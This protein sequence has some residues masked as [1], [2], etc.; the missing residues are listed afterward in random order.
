MSEETFIIVGAG[1]SGASAA[2]AMR[3]AGF[4]G[5]IVLIGAEKHAP[6]E[7]PPL[8]KDVLLVPGKS[9]QDIHSHSFYVDSR[10][11]FRFGV[12]VTSL[13][14][15]ARRI[16]LDTTETIAFD[17]LLLA[18]GSRARPYP[19]LDSLGPGVHVLRTIEDA[20]SLRADLSAG[21]RLLIVGG[22]V[23]G[24]EV[25]SSAIALGLHVTVVERASTIL[26]RGAPAPLVQTLRARHEGRG[27]KFETGVELTSAHKDAKG[28]FHLGAADG[29]TFAGDAIV[30][31]IGVE[32]NLELAQAA[33]LAFDD[34]VLIDAQGRTSSPGIFACGDLARQYNPFV[35]R[36]VRQETW[37]NA[38]QQ[39]AG[40]GRAMVTG[41]DCDFEPPWYW[42]DQF[43]S[44]F[45]VA[46]QCE[47][48]E[49]IAR[50][51][52]ANGKYILFG[53]TDGIVAAAVSVD[54]AREMRPAR[55]LIAAGARPERSA[56]VD[57][58]T[59]LRR[60]ARAIA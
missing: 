1:H 56:L 39:G 55:M 60:L 18:C 23:I 24:L 52:V 57:P 12:K 30:Y 7:R 4:E 36:Y 5:R 32:L 26:S 46:G 58:K 38:V 14:R 47:A 40:V 11:E 54:C 2:A 45:Q 16:V 35:G 41:Q 3:T 53:L 25:A 48:D 37:A 51:D 44:N 42:T 31:G 8:S 6:Y 20:E 33:D 17:K 43:G 15:D 29:R 10:I 49:W 28:H 9:K 27:V 50:G 22:G 59:D 34:G 21:R 19:M 13:D